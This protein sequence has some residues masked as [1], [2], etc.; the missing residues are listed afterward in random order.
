[1]NCINKLFGKKFVSNKIIII[2]NNIQLNRDSYL[3]TNRKH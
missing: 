1:M 3:H 2:I